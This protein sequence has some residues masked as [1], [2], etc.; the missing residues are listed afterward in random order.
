MHRPLTEILSS[1]LIPVSSEYEE[2]REQT[3]L[4]PIITK[5]E[6]SSVTGPLTS[7]TLSKNFKLASDKL[8]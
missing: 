4:P 8:F 2:S 5:L 1:N 6:L 7:K 3:I